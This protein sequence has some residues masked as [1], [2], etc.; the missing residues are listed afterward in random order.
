MTV[1]YIAHTAAPNQ[2]IPST[3]GGDHR[4]ASFTSGVG[5]VSFAVSGPLLCAVLSLLPRI[6]APSSVPFLEHGEAPMWAAN[7]PSS[8]FGSQQLSCQ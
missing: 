5:L 3:S 7:P 1:K 6:F 2:L 4:S 8:V